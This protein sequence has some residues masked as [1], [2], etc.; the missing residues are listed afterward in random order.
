MVSTRDIGACDGRRCHQ[1]LCDFNFETSKFHASFSHKESSGT[2]TW[3]SLQCPLLF[4]RRVF[5]LAAFF[6]SAAWLALVCTL[7]LHILF[8]CRKDGSCVIFLDNGSGVSLGAT[9]I[10]FGLLSISK[11]IFGCRESLLL[12]ACGVSWLSRICCVCCVSRSVQS[13]FD[14]LVAH[15]GVFIWALLD[16]L[17][18]YLD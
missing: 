13:H 12:L 15:V 5:Q 2:M 11:F 18:V 8:E 4:S 16:Q 3:T 7:A 9:W 10:I 17:F 14:G 6:S 1:W